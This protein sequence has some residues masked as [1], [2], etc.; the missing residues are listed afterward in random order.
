MIFLSSIF[1]LDLGTNH[2]GNRRTDIE[3]EV[4]FSH[5]NY[6]GEAQGLE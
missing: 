2:V 5:F 4:L 6:N 3:V 1:N